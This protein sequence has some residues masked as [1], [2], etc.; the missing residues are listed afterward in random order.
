MRRNIWIINHY[1]IDQF[2]NKSGRHYWFAQHLKE[3][4]YNPTVFCANTVH[5]TDNAIHVNGKSHRAITED[6]I[7]FVFVKTNAY[8]GNGPNRIRNMINFYKNTLSVAKK[9]EKKYGKPD[10]ILA[11]SVHPLTLVAGI[12]LA[13]EFNIPCICEVRDL[14]PESIVAYGEL[15]REQLFTRLLYKGEKWIYEQADAVVMTWE[16]GKDYI[17]DQGW[18]NDVP[19]TKIHHINNGVVIDTFDKN[20]EKYVLHDPDLD[21]DQYKNVV[22]AGSIRKVN[23]IG[24]L[25]DAAKI[26]QHRGEDDIRFL[27]YG[28]GNELNMLQKRCKDENINNVIFKGR[29]ERKYIPSIVKKSHINIVHNSST[30]L[31]KYGQSQNKLFE[32]L[33]AGRC[34][35]QTYSNGYS[36]CEK[37]NCGMH[38]KNQTAVQIAET[39][40]KASE[41]KVNKQMGINARK[42]AYDYDFNVL[43]EKLIHIIEH[44]V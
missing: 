6:D 1:A 9:H 26:V 43:T 10:V 2:M 17:V 31:D 39:I 33:A 22:Y 28:S 41:P 25:L 12:K 11:S 27:I 36:V 37:Y 44:E 24:L 5:N 30:S 35:V 7:P 38:A 18:E 16:G 8:D 19:L 15:K 21:T 34:I 32:Y 13:K 14:W 4:G 40:I 23:N 3:C 20:S 42:A 29:V